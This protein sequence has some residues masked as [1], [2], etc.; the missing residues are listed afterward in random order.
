MY[1]QKVI[2]LMNSPVN[3]EKMRDPDGE[4]T[5]EDTQNGETFSFYIKVE[6][7][8]IKKVSFW[9]NGDNETMAYCSII[10]VIAQ[11]KHLS[12][13]LKMTKQDI[14][15]AL[16]W[17]DEVNQYRLQMI[18]S[19]LRKSIHNYLLRRGIYY[20]QFDKNDI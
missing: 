12:E 15:D 7:G 5:I 19:A 9:T 11:G 13:A 1:S 8:T 6:F 16:D 17:S 18:I 14:I 20:A 3:L 4:G 2:E 10:T